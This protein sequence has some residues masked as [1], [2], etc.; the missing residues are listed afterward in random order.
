MNS[1]LEGVCLA[2]LCAAVPR[3]GEEI[4]ESAYETQEGRRRFSAVTGV[5]RR[6]FCP[7]ELYFSDLAAA[8]AERL[9]GE[10]GWKKSEIG[11]LVVVTQSGDLAYPATACILQ[12]RLGLSTDCAAFDINLGCSGFPYGL[13]VAGRM[14]ASDRG[15]KALLLVGDA[16]GKPNP[17]APQAPLFGD[18]AVAVA[19]ERGADAP[20]MMFS[21][22]TDGSGWDFIMER[23]AGGNPGFEKGTFSTAS[24]PDGRVYVNTH[25]QMKG[26]DVFNFSV[27][28]VPGAVREA[29][30]MAAWP[31]ESIEAFVFHQASRL[32]NETIRKSL[33]LDPSQTPSTLSDFG[34]TSS[35]TIPLTMVSQLG[36]RLRE[37][38]LRLL[39]CGFGVGLSWGTVT[40]EVGP[41]V[42]PP[43]VEV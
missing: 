10:L 16:A 34:N 25:Y 8:A 5:Y 42:C 13:L 21:L 35:A 37:S 20:P 9:L 28:V 3:H 18:A 24:G 1:K 4:A 31:P 19:L 27:R 39:L 26:E 40:C 43:I 36:P 30:R 6:R 12:H 41:M 15:A 29:V 11:S 7:P 22:H 32:I 33:H 17:A 23:R 2:G 14:L 38:T